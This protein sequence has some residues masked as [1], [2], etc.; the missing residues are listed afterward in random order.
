MDDINPKIDSYNLNSTQQ[1]DLGEEAT[2]TYKKN[3]LRGVGLVVASIA[4]AI[5]LMILGIILLFSYGYWGSFIPHYQKPKNQEQM[6][7]II[8]AK[9]KDVVSIS[10]FRVSPAYSSC[11]EVYFPCRES[12]IGYSYEGLYYLKDLNAGIKFSYLEERGQKNSLELNNFLLSPLGDSKDEYYKDIS[13]FGVFFP[14][15]E[16]DRFVSYYNKNGGKELG[17]IARF[18]RGADTA[19]LGFPF[20]DS[21][22]SKEYKWDGVNIA[23]HPYNDT[24]V[25]FPSNNCILYNCK[26]SVIYYDHLEKNW[27][28]LTTEYEKYLNWFL[29]QYPSHSNS[30][31]SISWDIKDINKG[32]VSTAEKLQDSKSYK[33]NVLSII[34]GNPNTSGGKVEIA[35]TASATTPIGSIK[36]EDAGGN[37]YDAP[38]SDSGWGKNSIS[39]SCFFSLTKSG[40]YNFKVKMLD[41][42]DKEIKVSDD[43]T[44]PEINLNYTS[45]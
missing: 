16:W 9:N 22:N 41:I 38:I 24:L 36:I 28:L 15:E 29:G 23:G 40:I 4:G 11:G 32:A 21:I 17:F 45:K 37:W 30:V 6:L 25:I 43:G 31:N 19:M 20:N 33:G 35:G 34:I 42:T 44:L 7:A 8:K 27:K 26:E 5:G 10:D 13:S 2:P 3:H 39:W 14:N 12:Q 18:L 1:D